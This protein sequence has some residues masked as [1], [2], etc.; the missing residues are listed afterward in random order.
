MIGGMGQRVS[1]PV[2]VG[3]DAEIAR[4]RAALERTAAGEPATVLVAGEAGIGKTR[5]VTEA[6]GHATVLGA[7]VLSGGCLD[8]GDG[9]LAYAP[10][11][12]ALRPLASLLAPA[13]LER[14]LDGAGEEL[15]RLVPELGP[16]GVAGPGG[17]LEP[18]RLFELLLGMLHRIAERIPVLLV[19]EDL[20]WA[21]QS[22]R[23]L[24]GFLVRNLRAGVALVLT[25]RSD[26]PGRGDQLRPFLAELERGGRAERV[27]LGRL[28]RR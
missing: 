5:L 3:R 14:V 1:C 9:V 7:V 2:L 25:C 8:V 27:E 21:D 6:V 22:T 10:V 23:D 20:H 13:E 12:E 26:E 24:L 15:A 28:G 17:P 4:L 19:A 11:V 16:R 18:S